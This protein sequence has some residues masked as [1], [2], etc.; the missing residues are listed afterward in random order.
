MFRAWITRYRV[1]RFMARERCLVCGAVPGRTR[2]ADYCASCKA[3]V[4]GIVITE[5]WRHRHAAARDPVN[6]EWS[7]LQRRGESMSDELITIT[8]QHLSTDTSWGGAA[9]RGLAARKEREAIVQ[10]V[11]K[12][13][14]DFGIIPGTQK[15][16]LLKPGAEKIADSLNLYPS[17]EALRVV[18]DWD[19]PLFHYAYRCTLIARGSGAT[20]ATG[21]GS[22]NTM[23]ARYRWREGKRKCPACNAEA[24]I[25]GKEDFGGGWVC[26]QK[27][28]GCGAKY[29]DDATS[30]TD[31]KTERV[32]ND[33]VFSQVN[34]AD[35]MAQKRALVAATLNL[36]FSEHFTQDLEDGNGDETPAPQK[37]KIATPQRASAAPKADSAPKAAEPREPGDDASTA[38][39]S[40]EGPSCMGVIAKI[41]SKDGVSPKGKAFTRY[42]ILVNDEWHNTFSD[43]IAEAA[44]VAK[45]SEDLVEIGYKE[46]QYGRNILVLL[47]SAGS[48]KS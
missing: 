20:I 39:S 43:S 44:K 33:D 5:F 48:F 40:I 23:E 2:E 36:G 24:I 37:P 26:W 19:R 30:I 38:P 34:T 47:T 29:A 21:I 13:G 46:T 31:Q 15:P 10:S 42:G 32:A 12:D 3:W 18:E 35:K 27:K 17:Y 7:A 8:P 14:P 4:A 22:C 1:R 28:G 11:L 16:T 25:K 45:A 9:E 41:T 6:Y